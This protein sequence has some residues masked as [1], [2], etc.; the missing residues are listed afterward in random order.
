MRYFKKLLLIPVLALFICVGCSSDETTGPANGEMTIENYMPLAVG[1]WWDYN[2][3][4]WLQDTTIVKMRIT[5]DDTWNDKKIYKVDL[6]YAY[7]N[8]LIYYESELRGYYGYPSDTTDYWVFLKEPIEVGNK[9][10]SGTIEQRDTFEIV[11]INKTI[12]VQAG[13]F[14]NC[15]KISST[16]N[17][18]FDY[19]P[20]VGIIREE[21][22]GV[23]T[24]SEMGSELFDY[25]LN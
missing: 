8:W 24:G 22:H 25:N 23:F 15:I 4:A 12:Y 1:N 3:A 13:I 21:R 17:E 18:V 5:E 6:Y 19:A 7:F 10:C 14:E 11:E 2:T 9:W 20:G 16:F